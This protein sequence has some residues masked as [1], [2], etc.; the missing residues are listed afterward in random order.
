MYNDSDDYED[1][2]LAWQLAQPNDV[3]RSLA[4]D[5]SSGWIDD[6]TRDA[7]H[8]YLRRWPKSKAAPRIRRMML[9]EAL[10]RLAS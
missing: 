5:Y 7:A 1:R 8:E 6:C 4:T 2:C 10:G 3:I 9:S